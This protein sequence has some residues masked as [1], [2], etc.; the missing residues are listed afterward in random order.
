M[1]IYTIANH[2]GGVGKTAVAAEVAWRLAQ[3]GRNVLAV[4]LDQQ[5]QLGAR[6]GLD[7]DVQLRGTLSDVLRAEATVA[8]AATPC[9]HHDRIRVL[10]GTS[11]LKD[12]EKDVSDLVTAL[13]DALPE[14][15]E[16]DTDVVID[17]PGDIG[18]LLWCGL[19]AAH[20]LIVP[21]STRPESLDQLDVL[22]EEAIDRISR[23]INRGLRINWIVPTLHDPTKADSRNALDELTATY[24]QAVTPPV[25]LYTTVPASFRYGAPASLY[26]PKSHAAAAFTAV[27]DTILKETR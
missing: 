9:P 20:V 8:Q 3:D 14:A 23:R 26:R 7:A 10:H 16:A 19:A 17:T 24:G 13:R 27:L 21:T 12:V 6:L 11:D 2:K 15:I 25:R 4:D 22:Q 18:D 5:G 1:T